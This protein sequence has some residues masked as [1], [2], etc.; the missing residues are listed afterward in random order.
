M[1]AASNKKRKSQFA[2]KSVCVCAGLCVRKSIIS[3]IE[4]RYE[5]KLRE[6]PPV[7]EIEKATSSKL[8]DVGN[9]IISRWKLKLARGNN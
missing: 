9:C 7:A 3:E 8:R 1:Q 2:T 4:M 5:I 6:F